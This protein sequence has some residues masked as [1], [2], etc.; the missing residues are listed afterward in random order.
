MPHYRSTS[1]EHVGKIALCS[2]SLL[3]FNYLFLLAAPAHPDFVYSILM[4]CDVVATVVFAYV[5]LRK[6]MSHFEN[7][8]L[9]FYESY[10]LPLP[11]ENQMPSRW[12]R[13]MF[14][15]N[16]IFLAN[17]WVRVFFLFLILLM[18]CINVVAF[19][20]Y[21]YDGSGLV[22]GKEVSSLELLNHQWTLL[23]DMLKSMKKTW[24]LVF[25]VAFVERILHF[26]VGCCI[27]IVVTLVV[28]KDYGNRQRQVL[29][30]HVEALVAAARNRSTTDDVDGD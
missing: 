2:V 26:L 20:Q 21:S 29:N 15:I 23:C 17:L 18:L 7:Q 19:I 14:F 3:F 28:S 10:S 6:D 16:D 4:I 5:L 30:V 12:E 25:N 8:L 24:E 13:V 9:D 22:G 1:R 11:D 27:M